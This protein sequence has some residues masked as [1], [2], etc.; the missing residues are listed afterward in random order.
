MELALPLIKSLPDS[1]GSANTK[2]KRSQREE[3][4]L[5]TVLMT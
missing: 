3:V 2:Q 1:G 5:F 4:F